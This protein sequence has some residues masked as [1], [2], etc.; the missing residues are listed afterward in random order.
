MVTDVIDFDFHQL[1][2]F[3]CAARTGSYS[4]AAR[5]LFVTPQAVSRGVQLMEA[6]LGMKLFERTSNG[7]V[8]TD[9]GTACLEPAR[10]AL[11]TL[12]RL[13]DMATN[14]RQNTVATLVLGVHSL[15]FRENGGSI[16]RN[17]LLAFQ[18]DHGALSLSIIEM[19]G[20]TIIRSLQEDSIDIGISVPP[21]DC[22]ERFERVFLKD[23]VIS[24]V[25]SKQFGGHFA[26]ADDHVTIEELTR[27]ELVLFTDKSDYN[28]FLVNRAREANLALPV[29]SLWIS[30][31]GDMHFISGTRLYAIRPQQHA[32][33]TI[34]DPDLRILPIRDEQGAEIHMPLEILM[35]KGRIAAAVEEDVL[36][37]IRSC[38]R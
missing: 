36:A 5:E 6:R 12:Q 24:A 37:F 28:D 3:V 35:K 9:F 8:P 13:Q 38:Y 18:K 20:D 29:S 31:H 15:C 4:Q 27:G 22:S 11:D 34:H 16:D 30:P 1:E 33:R 26:P 32:M 21:R 23:F 14:F 25:T 7:I 17:D 2:Y 10:E 19:P